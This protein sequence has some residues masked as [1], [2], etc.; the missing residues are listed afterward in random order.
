MY[1]LWKWKYLHKINYREKQIETSNIQ[2]EWGA[3]NDH[4]G[5]TPF[6]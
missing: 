2:L 6:Y 1:K 3:I 4:V 5:L